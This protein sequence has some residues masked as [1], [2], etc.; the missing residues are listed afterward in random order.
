MSFALQLA[1]GYVLEPRI[2][3]IE[4][5]VNQFV[6]RLSET[7][8]GKAHTLCQLR[9][10][11]DIAL[12]LADWSNR[13]VGHL[14][15][16]VAI[17]LLNVFLFEERSCRK[18][19]VSV[20]GGVGEE[21]IVHHRKQVVAHKSAHNI[22]VVRRDRRRIR[23]VDEHCLYRRIFE[24]RQRFSQ[25]GHVHHARRPSKRTAEHKV[26]AFQKFF[27]QLE[28]AAARKLNAAACVL[29]G[30]DN[31]GK[32]CNCAH[33]GP[34]VLAALYAVVHSNHSRRRGRVLTR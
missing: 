5:S 14:Q 29:P 34:A 4:G 9:E 1:T 20:I 3:S 2:G 25:F 32:H 8:L 22:V 18:N 31:A 10:H 11:L 17:R 26:W 16:V 28:C 6:Y 30:P 27:V 12:R 33:I 21:L 13:L 19:D 24:R 15:I 7:G 23:V